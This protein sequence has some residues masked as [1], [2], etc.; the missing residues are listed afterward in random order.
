MNMDINM[1]TSITSHQTIDEVIAQMDQVIERCIRE[2]SRLGYFAVLYRN[3]TVRV[4]DAIAAGRFEDGPRMERFDV[5][6]A[7]RYLDAIERFWGNQQPSA[8]W[9]AVFQ[10]RDAWSPIILQH[11]LLGMHAHINFDLA[12]AAAQAAPGSELPALK[13]DFDEIT[14]LLNEMTENIQE[15]LEKV[16]P[17]LGLIDY[18]GGRTDETVLAFAMKAARDLAWKVAQELSATAS[19]TSAFDRAIALHDAVVAGLAVPIRN[20]PGRWLR[21]ALLLI[22]LRE[23]YDVPTV[24]ETLRI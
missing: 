16:S 12:I 8:S 7:S 13:R 10:A 17:W 9:A 15:R 23:S 6:F 19:D 18:A 22:R 24:I 21:T 2:R 14:I 11:L 4:R 5:I 1:A 20:P 3:V